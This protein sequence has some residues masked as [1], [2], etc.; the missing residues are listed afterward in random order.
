MFLERSLGPRPSAPRRG[1]H[2][3]EV[4]GDLQVLGI[5]KGVSVADLPFEQGSPHPCPFLLEPPGPCLDHEA[6]GAPGHD[7]HRE[8]GHDAACTDVPQG[9]EEV[10]LPNL[11]RPRGHGESHGEPS[12]VSP[13][14]PPDQSSLPFIAGVASFSAA[15]RRRYRQWPAS[16]M[17]RIRPPPSGSSPHSGM[18]PGHRRHS[19]APGGQVGN[20]HANGM[21]TSGEGV[22][23]NALRNPERFWRRVPPDPRDSGRK[24][25]KIYTG[26][27]KDLEGR[28][29][30]RR[31]RLPRTVP[32]RPPR[33][34]GGEAAQRDAAGKR[35]VWSARPPIHDSDTGSGE[36]RAGKD[37]TRRVPRFRG[38]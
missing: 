8:L 6:E 32:L 37:I 13:A 7:L 24:R 38:A 23:P 21:R 34:G 25:C 19:P 26:A 3:G 22:P 31:S 11:H 36:P 35:L 16:S 12:K 2:P 33:G 28:G 9:P 14:G 20:V 1:R 10:R 18:G 27:W 17:G 5:E 29:S 30:S 4:H 15:A